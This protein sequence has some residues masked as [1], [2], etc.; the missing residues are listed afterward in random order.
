MQRELKSVM[1]YEGLCK[2]CKKFCKSSVQVC[3]DKTSYLLISGQEASGDQ[4]QEG[5]QVGRWFLMVSAGISKQVS[6]QNPVILSHSES[7]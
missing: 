4:E 6:R 1:S 5:L 7:F 2:S 3:C